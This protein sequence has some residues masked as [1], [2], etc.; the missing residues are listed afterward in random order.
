MTI[1]L[2]IRAVDYFC[3]FLY[4][5]IFI[6]VIISWLPVPPGNQ[7]IKVLYALTEPILS[8]IRALIRKSPLGRPGMM[9]DFSPIIAY[10]L[11]MLAKE[12]VVRFLLLFV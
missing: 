12:L 9:L 1:G 3:E 7:L 8:P 10:L 4:L 6:R 5:L 11:I 2:L